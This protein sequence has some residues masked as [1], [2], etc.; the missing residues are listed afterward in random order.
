VIPQSR[1]HQRNL[2]LCPTDRNSHFGV[3]RGL[4]GLSVDFRLRL[5]VNRAHSVISTSV[6]LYFDSGRQSS[7]LTVSSPLTRSAE[8]TG[9]GSSVLSMSVLL[10]SGICEK[11][12]VSVWP[13]TVTFSTS[14][15]PVN[16]KST[17]FPW[18]VSSSFISIFPRLC[19]QTKLYPRNNLYT[20]NM[21]H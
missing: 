11:S 10:P 4:C 20:L 9:H 14:P 7:I 5:P 8:S 18:G 17:L 2:A 13:L 21:N 15:E 6:M 12:N 3:I 19:L 16:E 1:L